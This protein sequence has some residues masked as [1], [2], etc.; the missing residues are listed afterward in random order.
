MKI[1]RI[2]NSFFMS[3]TFVLT[4]EKS[5]DCWLVDVGDMEPIVETIGERQVRG[6]LL[7]HTHYDHLYGINKLVE[8]FPDCVIY[9][10]QH[11]KE[12]LFSDKLNFSRYH[13]NSIVFQGKH[14]EVL[15]DG[16]EVPLFPDVTL[17]AIYTPGHDWS[18]MTYYTDK[19]IFTGDS[20][21]PNIKV[22]TSFP[23]SNKT[24]AQASLE[25]ILELCKTRDVYPGHNEISIRPTIPS[26]R[27]DICKAT[28]KDNH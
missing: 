22:I 27:K 16:D 15:E 13:D 17:K 18:C 7:T 10:S 23:K 11:G 26:F 3:N 8:R 1:I 14:V 6:V 12:G 24:E 4:D 21:I 25:R 28:I 20:Y 19:I 2:V 5:N 9:T